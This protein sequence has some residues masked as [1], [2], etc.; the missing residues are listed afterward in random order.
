M[1]VNIVPKILKPEEAEKTWS[2]RLLGEI[3]SNTTITKFA[4]QQLSTVVKSS[5]DLADAITKVENAY[6]K[7]KEA[8]ESLKKSTFANTKERKEAVDTESALLYLMNLLGGSIK[9]KS[10][11]KAQ[12]KQLEFIKEEITLI[13]NLRKDYDDLTASGKSAADST[14]FLRKQ[15]AEAIAKINNTVKALKLKIPPFDISNFAGKTDAE[16]SKALD[17]LMKSLSSSAAKKDLSVELAKLNISAEKYDYTKITDGLTKALSEIDEQ[18]ALGKEIEESETIG[19]AFMQMFNIPEEDIIRTSKDAIKRIQDEVTKAIVEFNKKGGTQLP[20][21]FNLMTGDISSLSNLLGDDKNSN[22]FV[23][24]V[25]TAKTKQASIAKSDVKETEKAY[26]DLLKKYS[27]FEYKRTEIAEQAAK[28]RL[29]FAKKF[30]GVEEIKVVDEKLKAISDLENQLASTGD[31]AERDTLATQL[32]AAKAEVTKLLVEMAKLKGI[33]ISIPLTIDKKESADLAKL[34]Y[35][36]FI[37]SDLWIESFE[38]VSNL[39]TGA[40]QQM[41]TQLEKLGIENRKAFKPKELKEYYDK[42]ESLKKSLIEK[43]PFIGFAK[44][45]KDALKDVVGKSDLD[46][47][48]K[49]NGLVGSDSKVRETAVIEAARLEQAITDERDKGNSASLETLD[50]LEKQLEKQKEIIGY[51]DEETKKRHELAGQITEFAGNVKDATSVIGDIGNTILGDKDTK[52]KE[53]FNDVLNSING[54]A[55]AGEG[56]AKIMTGDVI[57]GSIQVIKGLWDAT[58]TWLDNSNN[59]INRKVEESKETIDKLQKSYVGLERAVTKAI[60]SQEIAA[61]KALIS[62]KKMELAELKKQLAL[63]KSRKGKDKDTTRIAEIEAQIQSLNYEVSDAIDNIANNLLGTD[64]KSAAEDFAGVWIDAFLAGEDAMQALENKFGDMI[65]NMIVKAI[66][67]EVIASKL[68]PLWD[69]IKNLYNDN[70]ISPDEVSRLI[71]M[72]KNISGLINEDMTALKP[73]LDSLNTLYDDSSSK[74]DKSTLQKGISSVTETTAGIIEGYMNSVRT[75]VV[76]H[77]TLFKEMI[78]KGDIQM[79]INSNQLLVLRDSF[80]VQKSILNLL[81]AWSASE[82]GGRGMRVYLQN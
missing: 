61:Q 49:N 66:A 43:N 50:A 31:S 12:D 67:S 81:S 34:V 51:V 23:K 56:V 57:G 5:D 80:Q 72:S 59:E 70:V 48:K 10:V 69:E 64:I 71:A 19:N 42:L 25:T 40:I 68:Q 75:E 35:D 30:G 6:K 36:D 41:I 26:K 54:V 39:S 22:D 73:L 82:S 47:Y 29:D 3:N 7:A 46:V 78:M 37:N 60:G 18:F 9:D 21:D 55:T 20:T 79:T 28:D 1:R 16:I 74:A 24:G 4:K 45:M 2:E 32:E 63:E 52:G 15:Y 8:S 11:A 53:I 58:K 44:N 62:A 27:E 38:N 14:N 65:K 33:P 76:I 77:T 13:N 17:G